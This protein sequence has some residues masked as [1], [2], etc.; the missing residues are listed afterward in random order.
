[1]PRKH[2]LPAHPCQAPCPPLP[3]SLPG[4]AASRE[5]GEPALLAMGA[6]DDS[7]DR[8]AH[9]EAPLPVCLPASPGRAQDGCLVSNNRLIKQADQSTGKLHSP[10]VLQAIDLG[11]TGAFWSTSTSP[12]PG[13]RRCRASGAEPPHSSPADADSPLI[14][15]EIFFLQLNNSMETLKKTLHADPSTSAPRPERCSHYLCPAYCRARVDGQ[16][17]RC[18]EPRP[19]I[20]AGK[21]LAGVLPT[22]TQPFRAA[23]W[24]LSF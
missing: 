10:T 5:P 15:K 23:G 1:M 4:Q 19:A 18:C 3:G 8:R 24:I 22:H 7:T 6:G 13:P 16:A 20:T 21:Q 2:Q 17:G 14:W 11:L 12:S 9:I